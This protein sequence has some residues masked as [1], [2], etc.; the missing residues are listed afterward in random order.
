MQNSQQNINYLYPA[1]NRVMHLEQK[2][3]NIGMQ[4]WNNIQKSINLI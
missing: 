4:A 2:S 1:F 3:F